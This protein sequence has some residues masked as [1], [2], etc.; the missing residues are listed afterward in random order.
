MQKHFLTMIAI[1]LAIAS[2]VTGQTRGTF[3]SI[4][5]DKILVTGSSQYLTYINAGLHLSR[6]GSPLPGQRVYLD[7]LLLNDQ[8]NGQYSGGT[9]YAYD[10]SGNKTV[11]I[12]MIPKLLPSP[13][14]KTAREITLGTYLLDNYIRWVYPLPEAVIPRRSLIGRTVKFRWDYTKTVLN[15]LV[16]L[17]N[18]TSNT[19]LYTATVCAEEVDIPAGLLT[20]GNKYRFDLEVVGAMGQFKLST[21]TAPGSRIDFYYWGH[22]YFTVK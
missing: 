8:G 9:P 11:V 18:F 6:N 10:P 22:I 15:T 13:G 3:S 7:S 12:K 2:A 21:D 16:T 14:L 19:V 1:V 4:A 17:K 5:S 20:A